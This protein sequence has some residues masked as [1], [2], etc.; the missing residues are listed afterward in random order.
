M[1]TPAEPLD[2]G[3]CTLHDG[4]RLAW[5]RW[6]KPDGRD[7]LFFHGNPG[8]RFFRLDQRALDIHDV[9]LLTVDRPGVGD[10]DARPGR[11]MVDWPEDVAQLTDE[12]DLESFGVVGFSMGGPHALAVGAAMPERVTGIAVH[13]TPGPWSEPGFEELAPPQIREVRDA[14]SEDPQAA[15]KKFRERWDEQAGMMLSEPE[16]T[17]QYLV[18]NQLGEPDLHVLDDPRMLD[19]VVRDGTV[20]VKQGVEGFFEERMAG[21]VDEWGFETGDVPVS[22][23]VSHGTADR[24]VPVD[25][26]REIAKRLPHGRFRPFEGLGHFPAWATH[27]ELLGAVVGG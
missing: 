10:S 15:E 20:A 3:V 18:S 21:Y 8:S 27:D 23:T 25:I 1:G 7:V 4:R 12:L 13:A 16:E 2:D 17:I 5:S 11:R 6:G 14:F 9:T 22:V 24:W 19:M 26:G